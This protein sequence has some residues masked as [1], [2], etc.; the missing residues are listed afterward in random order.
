VA[1]RHV[2]D[3][4]DHQVVYEELGLG[5]DLEEAGIEHVIKV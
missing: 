2:L 1:T 3:A 4:F 5:P